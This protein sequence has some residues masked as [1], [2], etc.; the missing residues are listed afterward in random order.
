MKHRLLS[1]SYD[2]LSAEEWVRRLR[3]AVNGVD[4]ASAAL[5]TP[6][7]EIAYRCLKDPA[8]SALIGRGDLIAPDGEGI[9][10]GAK[11]AGHPFCY[12]K[13]AGVE[14]GATIAQICAEEGRSLFLFGGK[15][16][17]AERAAALL[18]EQY[19]GLV[20]AGCACGYGFD[21]DAIV[22]QIRR[23]GAAAVLVCLG[24]PMQEEWIDAHR[25]DCGALLCGLGG[26]LD[27]YAGEVRR[28]PRVWIRLRLE[29]LWRGFCQPGR[30]WRMRDI[31]RFLWQCRKSRSRKDAATS[32]TDS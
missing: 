15:T 24:S 2:D 9:L 31:P 1:L 8:L 21:S 30:F 17:T 22:R 14:L 16:G 3:S 4:A 7:A 13:R 32:G 6:N 29:W 12:P 5:Y 23:S 10:L 11:L 27:V 25:A 18:C 26:S 28:A 20:I 19:P